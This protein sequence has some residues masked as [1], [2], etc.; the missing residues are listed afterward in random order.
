MKFKKKQP[1]W[2][3]KYCGEA[4]GW[5]GRVMGLL[6]GVRIHGCDFSNVDR[7]ETT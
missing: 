3:C 4:V 2:C 6:F 1:S 7:G 5:I